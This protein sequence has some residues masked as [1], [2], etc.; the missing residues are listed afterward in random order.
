MVI[1]SFFTSIYA[2]NI[3]V[4]NITFTNFQKAVYE[5]E[6][7]RHG[8]FK[9]TRPDSGSDSE[10]VIE[11]RDPLELNSPDLKTSGKRIQSGKGES[12]GT[13][14]LVRISTPFP[15]RARKLSVP[16]VERDPSLPVQS[17]TGGTKRKRPI[18]EV[19]EGRPRKLNVPE[20]ER[21]PSLPVQSKT[22]GTK[23]K[24]PIEDV[25]EEGRRLCDLSYSH[26][27]IKKKHRLIGQEKNRK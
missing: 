8:L 14:K 7:D 18:E 23:R 1:F 22:R 27:S 24:R 10:E 12:T 15:K 17:K 25:R 11:D 26:P 6:G 20:V 19:Q 5:E 16:E 3:N 9:E 13:F 2:I 4:H 21:V